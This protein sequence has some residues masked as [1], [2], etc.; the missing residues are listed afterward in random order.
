MGYLYESRAR[1]DLQVVQGYIAQHETRFLH[2]LEVPPRYP[3]EFL[4][5]IINA[6]SR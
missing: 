6:Y 4:Q 1:L 5:P 2:S 3:Y